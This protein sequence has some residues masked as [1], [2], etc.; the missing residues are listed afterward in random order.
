VGFLVLLTAV[1]LGAYGLSYAVWP[2]TELLDDFI[3]QQDGPPSNLGSIVA[4]TDSARAR[5]QFV[6]NGLILDGL[7]RADGYAG[8]VPQRRLDLAQ[9]A[10]R[11]L[12]GVCCYAG[13]K[14][15]DF[16]SAPALPR[17]YLASRS[18][19]QADPLSASDIRPDTA[20]LDEPLELPSGEPGTV[21]TMI[22]KPGR[23]VLHSRTP[24]KRLLVITE[25]F[26][27]GWQASID[28]QPAPIMRANRDFMA[29][30]VEAG[31]HRLEL[32]FRPASL[33]HGA[34]LS[35]LGL[36]LI[37]GALGLAYAAGRRPPNP[38]TR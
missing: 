28:G 26:H 17:A 24:A 38:T 33:R 23:F 36:G 32:Q 3:M 37:V 25:S 11:R 8:L 31:E 4:E 35:S 6:G 16:D 18:V 12:A 7:R 22:D 9:P 2:K 29:V 10:A 20:F 5:G 30:P 14:G 34:M 15:W 27:P 13:S 21:E 19:V 1:D